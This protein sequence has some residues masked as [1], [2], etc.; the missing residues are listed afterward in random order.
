MVQICDR[1]RTSNTSALAHTAWLLGAVRATQGSVGDLVTPPWIT[2]RDWSS[3]RKKAKS[4]RKK[5]SVTG[6]RVTRPNLSC[7][8]A[9]DRSPTSDLVAGVSK[10]L[11][12]T[13]G[14]CVCHLKVVL[15]TDAKAQ[16][17]Q[18]PPDPFSAPES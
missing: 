10:L 9:R 8:V 6:K 7:V 11:A 5:R 13:S 12:C 3:M 14:S 17:Q 4:G 2:L 16:F 18:F 15:V 1:A